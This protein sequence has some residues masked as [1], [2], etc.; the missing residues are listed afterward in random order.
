ME[1]T[2]EQWDDF[3]TRL[4]YHREGEGVKDHYTADA[5]FIVQKKEQIW[6]MDHE[7]AE[8]AMYIEQ[9]SGDHLQYA[10]LKEYMDD[11]DEDQIAALEHDAMSTYDDRLDSLDDEDLLDLLNNKGHSIEL[12]G[13]VNRWEFVNAHFTREGA[14][15]FIARK[16]HD[17]PDGLRVYVDAAIY[18]HEFNMVI[19]NILSG[20]V[21][22]VSKMF[23]GQKKP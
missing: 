18:C 2:K 20:K 19:D 15:A 9:D 22:Y 11:L 10:T 17:Y 16:K 5:Y 7:Y 3:V 13:Y 4:R 21:D 12:V 6:G 23:P 1:L 14:D 8:G